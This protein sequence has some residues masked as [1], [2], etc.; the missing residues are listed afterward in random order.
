M[1]MCKYKEHVSTYM[2]VDGFQREDSV[3]HTFMDNLPNACLLLDSDFRY[4]YFN[5]AAVELS[6]PEYA[7]KAGDLIPLLQPG[8]D[9]EGRIEPYRE[10]L[11]SG[12]PLSREVTIP[13]GASGDMRRFRVRAFKVGAFLGLIWTDITENRRSEDRLSA[14]QAE[15]GALALHL[16]DVREE[17]RRSF[18]R[19]LHDELGQ[20][21]TAI[22]M[23]LRWVARRY[24]LPAPA[25]KE[26]IEKLLSVTAGA[27]RDVQR[28]SS[29]LR[30]GILDSLGLS[31]RDQMARRGLLG[32][33][34]PER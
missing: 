27:I 4:V 19:E 6:G 13:C 14:T 7:I 25:A 28:I 34:L 5:R 26:R 24:E 18:S 9:P 22:D 23:E 21:L 1:E 15:L 2:D 12:N 32:E 29:E 8:A 30:P 20:T 33:V 10:V 17:E 31:A 11:R 3:F 16:L